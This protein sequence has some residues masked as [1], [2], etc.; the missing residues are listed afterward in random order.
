MRGARVLGRKRG[1][2]A[3][4]RVRAG[5]TAR[6]APSRS[7]RDGAADPTAPRGVRRHAPAQEKRLLETEQRELK[8]KDRV[9]ALWKPEANDWREC[10]I[11]SK[12]QGKDGLMYYVHWSDFNRRN[13][14]WIPAALVNH[15]ATKVSRAGGGAALSPAAAL[16]GAAGCSPL[17]C[18]QHIR[19]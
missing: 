5:A 13:D 8:P 4:N 19:R 16:S 9:L 15:N 18:L 12:K 2:R 3:K 17:L 7:R 10:E 1:S 14:S 11:I 6:G